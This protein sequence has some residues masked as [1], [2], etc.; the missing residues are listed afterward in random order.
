MTLIFCVAAWAVWFLVWF[1]CFPVGLV[2]GW[3]ASPFP[4]FVCVCFFSC[5]LFGFW[6]IL[7]FSTLIFF[8]YQLVVIVSGVWGLVPLL[9]SCCSPWLHHEDSIFT[10]Y[11]MT[12]IWCLLCWQRAGTLIFPFLPTCT[13]GVPLTTHSLIPQLRNLSLKCTKAH[14]ASAEP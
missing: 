1:D 11:F 6:N 2:I 4:V 3:S 10:L 9:I 5:F 13:L 8:F 14:F 7:L 12:G